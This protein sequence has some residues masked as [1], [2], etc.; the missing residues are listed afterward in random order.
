[1]ASTDGNPTR[2]SVSG[3]YKRRPVPV[4]GKV[5]L[6]P[7]SITS[8]SFLHAVVQRRSGDCFAPLDDHDLAT[9]LHY[10]GSIQRLNSEDSN[11]QQRFV[12][13][14]GALHPNHI[15][16]G[17]PNGQWRTYLSEE[18]SLG[19]LEVRPEVAAALRA[20]AMEYFHFPEATVVALMTDGDLVAN[21][22][23]NAS[24]LVLRDAGVL[25]GHGALVAAA[26]GISFRILGGTGTPFLEQLIPRLAFRPVASGLALI[27]ARS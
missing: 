16:L 9:W 11:R 12:G 2:I 27:G 13:S 26:L 1:M 20:R 18:H 5:A 8:I 10:S 6:P 24:S 22:Y 7:P 3:P 15:L 21:Y 17:E 14:F 23:E 25:F 4:M 19:A